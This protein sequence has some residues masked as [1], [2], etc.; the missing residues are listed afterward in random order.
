MRWDA[1]SFFQ[2]F[3]L[4]KARRVNVKIRIQS[5]AQIRALVDR[6]SYRLMQRTEECVNGNG[7]VSFI[8]NNNCIIY[9]VRSL[10]IISVYCRETSISWIKRYNC[11]SI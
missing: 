5:D 8:I 6:Q 3:G 2:N 7:V 11:E 1:V 4:K 10:G 9:V